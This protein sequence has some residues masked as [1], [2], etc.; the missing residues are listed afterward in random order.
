MGNNVDTLSS[1]DTTFKEEVHTHL[2]ENKIL[3]QSADTF[4]F[5]RHINGIKDRQII[6]IPISSGKELFAV[7]VSA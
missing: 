3:Q 5:R 2:E 1:L 6:P 7:S 4:F